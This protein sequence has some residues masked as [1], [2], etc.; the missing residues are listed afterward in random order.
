M[1]T[2]SAFAWRQGK[3][4]GPKARWSAAGSSRFFNQQCLKPKKEI[5]Q[6]FSTCVLLVHNI[7]KFISYFALNSLRPHFKEKLVKDIYRN[8][9]CLFWELHEKKYSDVTHWLPCRT[10][11]VLSRHICASRSD[12]KRK[13]E[14]ISRSFVVTAVQPPPHPRRTIFVPKVY[15][16]PPQRVHRRSPFTWLMIQL[17]MNKTREKSCILMFNRVKHTGCPTS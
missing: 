5:L 9:C 7:R 2:T 15:D 16:V 14:A 17:C 13:T 6:F 12:R 8:E 10:P 3:P 11:V 4:K 1:E